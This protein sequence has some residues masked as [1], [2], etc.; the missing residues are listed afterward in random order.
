MANRERS[1]RGEVPD[2]APL[3]V[4]ELA[5]AQRELDGAGGAETHRAADALVGVAAVP[6]PRPPHLI[7]SKD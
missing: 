3:G 2:V 1:E 6:A 4:E 5:A 7:R